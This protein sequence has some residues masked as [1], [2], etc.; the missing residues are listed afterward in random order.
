ML[1]SLKM[2]RVY[3]S[4]DIKKPSILMNRVVFVHFKPV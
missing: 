4:K 1:Y 3:F 2:G